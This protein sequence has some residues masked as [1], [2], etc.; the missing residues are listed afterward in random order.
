[1]A[2][3]QRDEQWLKGATPE[4][5]ATAFKAGELDQLM[6]VQ[7]NEGGNTEAQMRG[8]KR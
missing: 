4:E 3:E 5:V 2:T 7:R 8:I 6:G 1:M